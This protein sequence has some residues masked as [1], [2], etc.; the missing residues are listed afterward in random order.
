MPSQTLLL[1]F[2]A[3]KPLFELFF[4]I[5]CIFGSIQPK[6]ECN[7][8]FLY[9][10]IFKPYYHLSRPLP[11]LWEKIDIYPHRLFCPKFDAEN[12]LF[13]VY[14]GILCIFSSVQPTDIH[15]KG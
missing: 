13:E 8:P 5:M 11:P 15:L 14:F 3:Y 2:D 4:G 12:L 7:F 10:L 1:K 6:S 9:N